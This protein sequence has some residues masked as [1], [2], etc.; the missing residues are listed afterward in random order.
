MLT[1]STLLPPAILL[2]GFTTKPF[3][4]CCAAH[5]Q[6]FGDLAVVL[7]KFV[8]PMDFGKEL[9]CFFSFHA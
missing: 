7:T 6:S 3:D 1:G 4:Q 5:L 9:L 8:Q 2:I